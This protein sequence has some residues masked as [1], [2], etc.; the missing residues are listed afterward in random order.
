MQ[1]IADAAGTL[2]MVGGQVV[3][4]LSEGKIIDKDTL[5]F[6]HENKT[7]ALIIAAFKAGCIIGCG[8]D[9]KIEIFEKI[10]KNV[11]IAFQI[12]DDIL[13]VVST[14]DILGK[15]IMSDAKN[16][17]VTFVTM[18]GIEK[19]EKDLKSMTD[20]ALELI[21]NF[22]ENGGFIYEYV[23]RLVTREK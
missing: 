22:G 2:G 17:K 6:I 18:Y 11:G 4:V 7:A 12:K 19:S 5:N 8:N 3:D 15:P 20:E 9:D 16:N 21:K 10:G 1:Y 23:K 13:D 14:Q